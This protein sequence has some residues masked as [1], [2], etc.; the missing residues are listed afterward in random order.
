MATLIKTNGTEIEIFPAKEFFSLK[1]MQDSIGGYIEL[2]HIPSE[3]DPSAILIIREDGYIIDL[4]VNK[5]ATQL[6]Y[7]TRGFCRAIVGDVI[8]CHV[9]DTGKGIEFK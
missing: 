6:V 1:E 3:K 4:P 2:L 5:N 9:T 7:A 8:F